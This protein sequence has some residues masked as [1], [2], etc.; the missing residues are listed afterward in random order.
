MKTAQEA[1]DRLAMISMVYAHKSLARQCLCGTHH[2]PLTKR[3]YRIVD[4][5]WRYKAHR[6]PLGKFYHGS[7]HEEPRVLAYLKR[8]TMWRGLPE[9]KP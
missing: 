2:A 3:S 9:I 5:W 8:M 1:M 6:D 7:T 4:R